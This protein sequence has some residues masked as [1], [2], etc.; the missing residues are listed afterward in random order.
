MVPTAQAHT[1]VVQHL[2]HVVRVHAVHREGDHAQPLLQA[3][4]TE[5]A[6]ALKIVPARRAAAR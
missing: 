3:S 1:L 2:A 5:N 6:H 4:G